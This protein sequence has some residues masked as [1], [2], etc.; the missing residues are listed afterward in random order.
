[1]QTQ[2]LSTG[3]KGVFSAYWVSQQSPVRGAF[4]WANLRCRDARGFLRGRWQAQIWTLGARRALGTI[5]EA[6]ASVVCLGNRLGS[7]SDQNYT[8]S[9]G[10]KAGTWTWVP[11]V[12][13]PSLSTGPNIWPL[14]SISYPPAGPVLN[15]VECMV[16]YL[17]FIRFF[18]VKYLSLRWNHNHLCGALDIPT[19]GYFTRASDQ[20]PFWL[21][22]QGDHVNLAATQ[23]PTISLS[24]GGA[25]NIPLT[26]SPGFIAFA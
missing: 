6:R 16:T 23:K 18:E 5:V 24:S 9:C 14:S 1:M 4:F 25:G 2:E 17:I 26:L 7:R 8:A 22:H 13:T 19:Q 3:L 15:I 10:D 20:V 11:R 12:L 21:L